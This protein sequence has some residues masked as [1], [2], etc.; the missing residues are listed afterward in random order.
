MGLFNWIGDDIPIKAEV[1]I[2]FAAFLDLP[3]QSSVS[4]DNSLPIQTAL[5]VIFRDL[6]EIHQQGK[7]YGDITPKSLKYDG[8]HWFTFDWNQGWLNSLL[9]VLSFA[10]GSVDVVSEQQRMD[11]QKLGTFL[12]NHISLDHLG[13]NL[14]N[15]LLMTL[16]KA[17][18]LGLYSN[19]KTVSA[20]YSMLLFKLAQPPTDILF[21]ASVLNKIATIRSEEIDNDVTP[22]GRPLNEHQVF[23]YLYGILMAEFNL[24]Q[25]QQ[26]QKKNLTLEQAKLRDYKLKRTLKVTYSEPKI[27]LATARRRY[28]KSQVQ[29]SKDGST[30]LLTRAYSVLN[31]EGSYY[32]VFGTIHRGGPA[33]YHIMDILDLQTAN[34]EVALKLDERLPQGSHAGTISYLHDK[35]KFIHRARVVLLRL[36]DGG[37]FFTRNNKHYLTMFRMDRDL[38]AYLREKPAGSVKNQ[39]EL[40]PACQR[41]ELARMVVADLAKWHLELKMAYRDYKPENMGIKQDR[42]T[43]KIT[44]VRAID[45]ETA[46]TPGEIKARSVPAFSTPGLEPKQFIEERDPIH[47]DMTADVYTIALMLTMILGGVLWPKWPTKMVTQKDGTQLLTT[48]SVLRQSYTDDC[49]RRAR[50]QYDGIEIVESMLNN[51]SK[52]RPTADEVVEGFRRMRLK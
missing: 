47:L 33:R 39:L 20:I 10:K 8:K 16:L 52:A 5:G 3:S 13:H 36:K 35:Q 18:S 17:M 9:S 45:Y 6:A 37:K 40:M 48:N 28:E 11:M 46:A 32:M 27:K 31:I 4:T 34:F 12:V 7:F 14:A 19:M 23:A 38:L 22:E 15:Q 26:Q 51:D 42:Q 25:L 50:K 49:L 30:D 44:D 24:F 21:S 2:D 1:R 43:K 41:L 29:A